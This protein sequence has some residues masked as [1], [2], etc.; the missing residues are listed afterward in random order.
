MNKMI[1][2]N[3]I[4]KEIQDA[5]G[6]GSI[7]EEYFSA[8]AK[9]MF[10]SFAKKLGFGKR[11]PY[12]TDPGF[13]DFQEYDTRMDKNG[14][15]YM[16]GAQNLEGSLYGWILCAMIKEKK[17]AIPTDSPDDNSA[18][19][20]RP[21][22]RDDV[23]D[24]RYYIAL[25]RYLP[26]AD[27]DD[28]WF[29]YRGPGPKDVTNTFNEYTDKEKCKK[30]LQD[31]GDMLGKFGVQALKMQSNWKRMVVDRERWEPYDPLEIKDQGK[32]VELLA[33]QRFDVDNEKAP[34][35]RGVILAPYGGKDWA[36]EVTGIIVTI[37]G[38]EGYRIVL[39]QGVAYERDYR[40][41]TRSR[42][43]YKGKAG[44]ESAQLS[45][46]GRYNDYFSRSET[47][48]IVKEL[49][50]RLTSKGLDGINFPRDWANVDQ[51]RDAFTGD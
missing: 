44:L 43:L 15:P 51:D 8:I 30:E 34:F 28:M 47:K 19:M 50:K 31:L 25:R 12:W 6:T 48:T 45:A 24:L 26:S 41:S 46:N 27:A 17:P 40:I 39:N 4:L 42:Y 33:H 35:D 11:T 20:G 18:F 21:R 5:T 22:Y 14:M 37:L 9:K 2:A 1:R 3:E 29:L 23:K 49:I 7:E 36:W 16:V 38:V 10:V 32:T 13:Y